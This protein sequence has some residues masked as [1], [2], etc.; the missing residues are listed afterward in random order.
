M[1]MGN[2]KYCPLLSVQI[3]IAFVMQLAEDLIA[4]LD[5]ITSI[6]G[7]LNDDDLTRKLFFCTR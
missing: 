3:N 5:K 1:V 4:S 6:P 7:V 2:V